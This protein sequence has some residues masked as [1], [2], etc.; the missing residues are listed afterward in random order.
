MSLQWESRT[1]FEFLDSARVVAILVIGCIL[2]LASIT[3]QCLVSCTCERGLKTRRCIAQ[4]VTTG[5]HK[6]LVLLFPHL[7][8]EKKVESESNTMRNVLHF[9]DRPLGGKNACCYYATL[10]VFG[11]L[12]LNVLCM[13]VL[14]FFRYFPIEKSSECKEFDS[15]FRTLYC[16]TN[17][18]DL[19]ITCADIDIDTEVICYAYRLDLP[20]AIGASYGLMKFAAILVTMGTF[21]AKLWIEYAPKLGNCS[22]R[23]CKFFWMFCTGEGC[24]TAW[25]IVLFFGG[26]ISAG[27]C[28]VG[29]SGYTRE[30]RTSRVPETQGEFYYDISYVIILSL[31]L[32]LYFLCIPCFVLYHKDYPTYNYLATEDPPA[33]DNK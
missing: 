33:P 14:A 23:H 24:C 8:S 7:F 32:P 5:V 31:V 2:L 4:A 11:T 25:F 28:A 3:L 15:N 6:L 1:W 9:I 13:T 16:F 26:L 12:V 18:S 19:P 29:I 21:A 30:I 10:L 27:V 22:P 17:T 20:M